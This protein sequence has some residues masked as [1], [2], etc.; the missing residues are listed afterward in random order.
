VLRALRFIGGGGGAGFFARDGGGGGIFLLPPGDEV[1]TVD[2]LV[3]REGMLPIDA[4]GL[5]D[6]VLKKR[7]SPPWSIWSRWPAGLKAS[8]LP[9]RRAPGSVG[10]REIFD[11]IGEY[12]L[13]LAPSVVAVRL[14]L[15]LT[16]R[17]GI[18]GLGEGPRDDR[19]EP[20]VGAMPPLDGGGYSSSSS[21]AP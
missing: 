12:S 20:I 21:C 3:V 5:S 16:D 1:S 17:S 10:T 6:L 7:S 18:E 13:S 14:K 11:P 15:G 9:V 4:V 8:L 2:Q 19:A